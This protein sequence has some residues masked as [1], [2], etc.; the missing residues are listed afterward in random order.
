M[1]R[2]DTE[3]N[4]PYATLVFRDLQIFDIQGLLKE[5]DQYSCGVEAYQVLDFNF[6]Q[7]ERLN[8]SEEKA[9]YVFCSQLGIPYFIIFVSEKSGNYQIFES[10]LEKEIIVFKIK[11]NFE[12]YDFIEWWRSQQSFNQKKA[13]YNAGARISQSII[14]KDLFANSLA[15][16]VNIDGFSYSPETNKVLAIYEK[17]IC[18]YKPP[19]TV[20]NYD[21]NKFF[22]GTANRSGDFPS[23]KI[24]FDLTRKMD[25]SLFLFTFDTSG[26]RKVGASRIVDIDQ[27]SG[28]SY[29]QN[30]KPTANMFKENLSG[31]RDW[32]TE[33][34]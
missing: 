6:I 28:I 30:V 34:L 21:P 9:R 13:M 22:H 20:D 2:R 12:K 18:T 27:K 25:V 31:L 16:G 29:Y 8:Q 19:Y 33:N 1:I 11:Y 24:L 14:D 17:R 32:L 10:F 15:W 5:G 4:H 3:R 23:W 7:F 26:G